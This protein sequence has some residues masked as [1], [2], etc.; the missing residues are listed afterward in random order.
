MSYRIIRTV[1]DLAQLPDEELLASLGALRAAIVEAKRQHGVAVREHVIPSGSPFTFPSFNWRP[2]G[3]QRLDT[4]VQL[5]PETPIDELAVRASA[6]EALRELSIFCIE[7]LSAISEQ[8]L[9]NEE[10]I[11]ART[12]GRLRE[13]LARVGLDFL[14]NPNVEERAHEQS[15]AVLALPSDARALALRGLVDSAF[16]SSL[17]LRSST[18]SRALAHGFETVGQ[19]RRLTLASLCENFGKREAR[20]IYD[21]LLATDRPF[22]SS[23]SPIDLWR[24][25]L[26]TAKELPVPTA[27]ETPIA[28]LRPW[29]GTSVDSLSACGIDTLG[30]LRSVAAQGDV[31]SFRGMGRVTSDRVLGFLG[32]YVSPQPYRRG[33]STATGFPA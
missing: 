29:L 2:K 16:V 23:A 19:L 17:G 21:L 1:D 26:M 8:E 6:R 4:P 7:D 27:G 9:L 10:A 11:G 13:M 30:C 5:K 14:P 33:M 31:A 20:E 3:P 24:H 28:E 25:G 12:V 32:S 18:L 15:K 22:T